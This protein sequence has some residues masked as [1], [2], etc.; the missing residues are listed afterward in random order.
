[1]A[2]YDRAEKREVH[3]S[4]FQTL[5]KQVAN[6]RVQDGNQTS[7]EAVEDEPKVVESIESLCISCEENGETRLL[8]TKIP[9]FREVILMSFACDHCGF[10]NTEVKSAGQIQERGAKYSLKVADEEDMQRQIVKSDTGVFRLEDLDIEM[11]AGHSQLTNV[12]GVLLEILKDLKSGQRKRKQ[13]EPELWEKIDAIVQPLLKMTL[14]QKFPFTITLDDPSGNSWIEPSPKDKDLKYQKTDYPRTA[15]QN[16]ELGLGEPPAPASTN[17]NGHSNQP[18]TSLNGSPTAHVVPQIP[19]DTQDSTNLEGV[20]I[21]AGHNYSFP[22]PC[23]GCTKPAHLNLQLVNIPYFK[24][25]VVSAVMCLHC[26]YRSSDVKTG[27]EVPRLGKRIY[28]DVREPADLRRD[29]LKS[30]TCCVKIDEVGVEV[31]P[32]T[33]GGRFTTVEGLLTQIRDDLRF[34]VFESEEDEAGNGGDSMPEMKRR[35]WNQFF[36]VINKAIKGEMAFRILLE[37]PLAN[38]YVQS[39]EEELEGKDERLRKEDYTRSE[40]EDDE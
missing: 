9:Y 12:E 13:E 20:D 16:A 37:D 32:G 18:A 17:D 22:T 10:K 30:E 7:Q 11:P 40:E 29:I 39:L 25:V 26:N 19:S 38:S 36:E 33:M 24:E 28:L 3:E 4:P 34:T 6:L 2:A 23:P 5:S 21:L 8:L 15:T 27:G 14:N 35:G 1:M 31:V